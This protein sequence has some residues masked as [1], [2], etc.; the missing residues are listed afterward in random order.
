[1][2]CS[3]DASNP[4]EGFNGTTVC[5]KGLNITLTYLKVSRKYLE[6]LNE[7]LRFAEGLD[8]IMNVRKIEKLLEFLLSLG[9]HHNGM[10][11]KCS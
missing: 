5:L 10:I 9:L 8:N 1:M 6:D 11:P 7:T 4:L 3:N 2:E